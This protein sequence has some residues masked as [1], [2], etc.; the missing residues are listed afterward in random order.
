MEPNKIL[1]ANILDL[2]FDGRNKEYGA[3]ELRITYPERIKKSII[4][5][6]IIIAIAITGAALASSFKPNND[7]RIAYQEV[8]IHDIKADET[9]EEP[10]P[11]VKKPEPKP[12]VQTERLTQMTVV[13]D[14]Q[15]D[16]E[17]PTN[18]DLKDAKIDVEKKD[19]IKDEGLT[20]I[21]QLDKTGVIEE[22][23]EK[24]PVIWTDVQVPAKYEGDWIKFLTRNLNG[25]T[26]VDNGAPV[27][28][29]NVMIQFVVDTEG[30]LSDI[31]ALT[32]FGY[33]MEQEAIRVLKKA[34]GWKPGI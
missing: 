22:K 9:K 33:G 14:E 8:T 27:G 34:K 6:F 19:G 16:D 24:E 26:P 31:V 12:E 30:N 25:N 1:S 18:D 11:E 28:R 5:V 13:P 32:S 21:K 4:V 15:A 23:I 20:E 17:I 29:Y 2:I 3:Y 7:A 10:I